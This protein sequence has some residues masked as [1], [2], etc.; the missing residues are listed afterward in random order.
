M[1]YIMPRNRLT[2]T[3]NQKIKILQWYKEVGASSDHFCFLKL[4]T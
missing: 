3:N 4:A 2:L 1:I